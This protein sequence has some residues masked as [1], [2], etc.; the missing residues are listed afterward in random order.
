MKQHIWKEND[1]K[2]SGYQFQKKL[3]NDYL[4]KY[5]NKS[6]D[7]GWILMFVILFFEIW[8]CLDLNF[9]LGCRSRNVFTLLFF[10][11]LAGFLSHYNTIY[12][13]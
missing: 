13:I 2:G 12:L 9:C 5:E 11:S 10:K 4:Q 8:I 7:K 1:T 6:H 3:I